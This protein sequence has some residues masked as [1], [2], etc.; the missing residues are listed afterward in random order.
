MEEDNSSL[1]LASRTVCSDSDKCVSIQPSS[2]KTVK[3][4]TVYCGIREVESEECVRSVSGRH[5]VF[6]W[7][8][9]HIARGRSITHVTFTSTVP[10]TAFVSLNPSSLLAQ[11]RASSDNR[12]R[13]KLHQDA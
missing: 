10:I 13:T 7:M 2:F 1:V 6:V 3:S 8:C 4:A 5:R 11:C 12:S 9:I